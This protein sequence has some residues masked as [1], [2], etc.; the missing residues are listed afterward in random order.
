MNHNNLSIEAMIITA[1]AKHFG[2]TPD[3]LQS[4]ESLK[5]SEVYKRGLAIYLIRIKTCLSFDEIGAL[6]NRKKSQASKC[7]YDTLGY[8]DVNYNRV[9]N[10][11]KQIEIY[12][13]KIL[14]DKLAS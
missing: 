13:E 14:K 4:G 11:L 12:F 10:D 9:L 6:F 1:T 3:A 7:Y 2:V 8:I 5:F